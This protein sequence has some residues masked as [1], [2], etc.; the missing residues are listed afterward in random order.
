MP[1]QPDRLPRQVRR[2]PRAVYDIEELQNYPMPEWVILQKYSP[3]FNGTQW[4][5]ELEKGNF[6]N[7][8]MR[9]NGAESVR[10]IVSRRRRRSSY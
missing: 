8:R 1:I 9:A 3:R 4:K 6:A 2:V 7:T 5:V 10:G